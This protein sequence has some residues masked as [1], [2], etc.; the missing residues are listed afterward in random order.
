MGGT[1]SAQAPDLDWI[2]VINT[3]SGSGTATVAATTGVT[4]D[5]NKAYHITPYTSS[6]VQIDVQNNSMTNGNKVDLFANNTT[7]AQQFYLRDAGS[8]DFFIESGNNSSFCLDDTSGSTANGNKIQLWTCGNGNANQIWHVV[9]DPSGIANLY[10]LVNGTANK[11][12]DTSGSTANGTQLTIWDCGAG[13]N[14]QRFYI[15]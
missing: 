11:C 8:G 7:T 5:P 10:T 14:N 3:A 6:A 4:F 13:N 1:S 12:L 2:E 9:P 15:Q